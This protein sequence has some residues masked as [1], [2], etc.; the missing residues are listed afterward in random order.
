MLNYLHFTTFFS[1]S[2][3]NKYNYCH[4]HYLYKEGKTI[5]NLKTKTK[6]SI[7]SLFIN[8]G[9]KQINNRWACYGFFHEIPIPKELA[10]LKKK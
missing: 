6:T 3:K 4:K 9:K 7:T 1:Q 10:N 8:T 2:H 5:M